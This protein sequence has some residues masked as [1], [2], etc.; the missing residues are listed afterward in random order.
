V[1]FRDG[2][3]KLISQ[4]GIRSVIAGDSQKAAQRA[5]AAKAQQ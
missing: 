4:L 5:A 2:Y 3:D 1:S